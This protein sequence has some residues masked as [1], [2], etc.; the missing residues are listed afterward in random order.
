MKNLVRWGILSTA[1]I[2]LKQVIPA[3]NLSKNGSVCAI[4]SRTLS[5]ASKAAN[6][7][8]IKKAYGSYDELFLDDEI[9]AIYNPLPNNLH[10]EFT[11]KALNHRKHVLCEKPIGL[12]AGEAM[13]LKKA[14]TAYPTLKVMEG[15]MY[16]FHPQ[17]IAAKKIVQNGEIGKVTSMQTVFSYCNTDAN[18]IRNKTDAGGGALMDIGC[19]CISFPRFILDQEPLSVVGTMQLDKD[20]GTDFLSS[21]IL[22]FENQIDASFLCT[23]QA[24]PF[25]RFHIMG[26]EG[27]LEVEIPCNAPIDGECRVTLHSAAGRSVMLFKANQYQLQCEAFA[28][29]ILKNIAVPYSITD[30]VKNMAVIEAIRQS[31]DKKTFV[32]LGHN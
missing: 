18:N 24:H 21:G 5:S 16:K 6:E 1:T 13:Q 8:G 7:L 4:A 14:L 17:W 3:I 26:T 2:G 28:D 23:T 29:C 19:Y 27:H 20:F 25:Q 30:A 11:L 31:A 22:S 32:N 10:L 15:F 12:N 9:D